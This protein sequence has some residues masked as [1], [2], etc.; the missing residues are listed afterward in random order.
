MTISPEKQQQEASA[1]AR[2]LARTEVRRQAKLALETESPLAVDT[3]ERV[4]LRLSTIDPHDGL[5]LERIIGT[6]DL[7][8]IAYFEAGLLA[9]K[10]VC[11]IEVHDRRGSVI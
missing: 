6:S 5:A 2:Y 1:K 9:A 10:S 3:E 11:R 4:R 7:L 8:P